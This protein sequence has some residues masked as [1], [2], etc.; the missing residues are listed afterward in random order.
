MSAPITLRSRGAQLNYMQAKE[1][2]QIHCLKDIEPIVTFSYW[3][4]VPNEYPYDVAFSTCHLLLPI[5]VA[6]D[7]ESLSAVELTELESI[8]KTY[9]EHNYDCVME[10]TART[11]SVLGHYHLHLL[12][13]YDSRDDMRL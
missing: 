1:L 9:V 5:R 11:R 3:K 13:Y 6:P 12:K 7:K 10:N 8:M 2:G 4:I